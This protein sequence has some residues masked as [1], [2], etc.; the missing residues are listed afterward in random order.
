MRILELSHAMNTGLRILV[1][2]RFLDSAGGICSITSTDRSLIFGMR[3]KFLQFA[4]CTMMPLP[5]ET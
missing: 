5:L 1:F 3:E 2:L 4:L